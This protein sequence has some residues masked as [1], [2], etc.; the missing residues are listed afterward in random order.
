MFNMS[1]VSNDVE[2]AIAAV[3]LLSSKRWLICWKNAK[4]M[5]VPSPSHPLP[6]IVFARFAA[7]DL[8]KGLTIPQWNC[9]FHNIALFY[10]RRK[11]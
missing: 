10:E 7:E 3:D 8:I 4:I 2:A 11:T 9:L 5:C 1:E 6:E